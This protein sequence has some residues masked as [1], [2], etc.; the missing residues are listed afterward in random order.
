[1]KQTFFNK[2]GKQA[3]LLAFTLFIQTAFAVNEDQTR[4]FRK[5][6]CADLVK[7]D[8][9][10]AKEICADNVQINED[11]NVSG[12]VT[13]NGN[14]DLHGTVTV[15]EVNVDQ[16]HIS[17]AYID[18]ASIG[19]EYTLTAI[20]QDFHQFDSSR[21]LTPNYDRFQE[22]VLPPTRKAGPGNIYEYE[23]LN[24][25]TVNESG[26]TWTDIVHGFIDFENATATEKLNYYAGAER[27]L[28]Q[29]MIDRPFS[30]NEEQI[31]IGYMQGWQNTLFS[32][33]MPADQ[34]ELAA[35]GMGIILRGLEEINPFDISPT[36]RVVLFN[37][38]TMAK[39]YIRAWQMGTTDTN[40]LGYEY[41]GSPN[42][43]NWGNYYYSAAYYPP[44]LNLALLVA[45]GIN[46]DAEYLLPF[47]RA[48]P[49]MFRL[50]PVILQDYIDTALSGMQ[51]GFY[52]HILRSRPY[53][54]KG[55]STFGSPDP[56]YDY[57]AYIIALVESGQ[58][59]PQR[60]PRTDAENDFNDLFAT[61]FDQQLNPEVI[62]A[63]RFT[64]EG[65]N[66][67]PLLQLC[68]DA[69]VMTQTE[70]DYIEGECRKYYPAVKEA[71]LNFLNTF[72]LDINS[73]FVRA[74]R[75]TRYDD[76]PGEWGNKFIVNNNGNV[77]GIVQD[78]PLAGETVFVDPLG[79][80]LVITTT[81]GEELP[82][83]LLQDI[84]L[85]R[86]EAFGDAQYLS[87]A[88]IVLKLNRDSGIPVFIKT[89]T[90]PDPVSPWQNW[91]TII[92]TDTNTNMIEKLHQSGEGLIVFFGEAINFYLDKW[93]QQEFGVDTWQ[94]IFPTLD[95]AIA[96]ISNATRYLGDLE[97]PSPVGNPNVRG[98]TYA[99][100][101]HYKPIE[102]AQGPL[103]DFSQIEAFYNNVPW[104]AT[105]IL[106]PTKLTK[107]FDRDGN[108]IYDPADIDPIT[109][110]IR[111]D[112]LFALSE[113]DTDKADYYAALGSLEIA[114]GKAARIYYFSY[115]YVIRSRED[116]LARAQES[117]LGE[118]FSPYIRSVFGKRQANTFFNTEFASG[119]YWDQQSEVLTYQNLVNFN[120]PHNQYFGAERS[121]YLHEF[122]MG[123]SLQIPL[124]AIRGAEGLNSWI[125]QAINNNVT[126]EGWAVFMELFFGPNFTT[127]L[128]QTDH[129]GNVID[130]CG[131]LDP[132]VAVPAFAGASRIAARL[133]WDTGLHYSKYKAS[134]AEYFR[135]FKKDTFDA[136]DANSEVA[137]RIPTGPTQGLNYALGFLLLVGIYEE[138]P[139][140][141]GQDLYCERQNNGNLIDRY[142]FDTILLDAQGYFTS[143][144][145][146]I[147]NQLAAEIR[148]GIPP[149]DDPNYQGYPVD[150]FEFNTQDYVPGTNPAAYETYNNPYVSGGFTFH[151]APTAQ[152]CNLPPCPGI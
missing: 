25:L 27:R 110:F 12:N 7:A 57:E 83:D 8:K 99:F 55:E 64:W 2:A 5:K 88:E 129:Y 89:G 52:P 26:N 78:G 124:I 101:Q 146:P 114:Q 135:G 42:P 4:T 45:Y 28:Y 34:Q 54:S 1:M 85:Q 98:G 96:A 147:I 63:G 140:L 82:T 107:V 115:D 113:V 108:V 46:T 56:R 16:A 40:A 81:A 102:D 127:Y 50:Y 35:Q 76:Y 122:I 152:P 104:D 148:L 38:I 18:V 22:G 47:A 43:L 112:N 137:Q 21:F 30:A 151:F 62:Y 111:V 39:F 90:N 106:D 72:Y 119:S 94:E 37:H 58:L 79:E 97:D 126:A 141:I 44:F 84:E 150:A 15:A 139:N 10:C 29:L 32:S 59:I 116:W 125:S 131:S 33:P 86:D 73:P 117:G 118:F 144:L 3:L 6:V 61:D 142:L 91:T 31:R 9:V 75:M 51:E 53:S 136:F 48:L 138:L 130:D 19:V 13:I 123:H 67:L 145:E 23:S 70:A 11:L 133:K 80:N 93:V 49:I 71:L 87:M 105:P 24:P 92:D 66:P 100:I 69:G 120:D 128:A 77:V 103:Y 95:A 60:D 134:M 17:T 14:V 68:V 121:T 36:D 109:G 20:V 149:F 143:S 132:R 41:F 74:L 65:L